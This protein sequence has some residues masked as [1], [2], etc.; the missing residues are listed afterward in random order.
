MKKAFF[1]LIIFTLTLQATHVKWLGGYDKALKLAKQEAKPL[2]VY[3]IK[4]D[5]PRCN[6]ILRDYFMNQK[7]IALLNKK[8][9]SV[10][11]T[12]EGS[13]NYP[14]EMYYATSFPTL[15]FVDSIH[16][17][18]LSPPLSADEISQTSIIKALAD[19]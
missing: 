19:E 10:I 8:F 14:I 9:I 2:L 11:V 16:E 18:F 1:L 15:F 7:Y 17:T 6:T 3:L 5:T 4:K 12:Y 13:E